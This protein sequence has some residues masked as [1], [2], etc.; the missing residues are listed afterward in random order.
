[1]GT[2][3]PSTKGGGA[4][5]FFGPCLLRPNGWM[6]EAGTWHGGRLQ[7]RRFCVIWGPSPLPQKGTEDPSPIFGP[8]LLRP[9]GWVHRD[10]TRYGGRPQPRQVCVRWGPSP[11][12]KGG[13]APFPILRVEVRISKLD[14][15]CGALPVVANFVALEQQIIL[16]KTRSESV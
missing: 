10:A 11:S 16:L 1:M 9:N 13:R 15:K 8:F 14:R 12:P 7:P 6:D 2:T 4:P 3:L 5:H